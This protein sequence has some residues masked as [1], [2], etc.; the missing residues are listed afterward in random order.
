[1]SKGVITVNWNVR[2]VILSFQCFPQVLIAVF[3]DQAPGKKRS[4][5]KEGDLVIRAGTA[6]DDDET[7]DDPEF[8]F[9][10]ADAV[11]D[12]ELAELFADDGDDTAEDTT[13]DS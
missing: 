7:D 6:D 9:D 8:Q 5:I 4:E 12:E 2:A 13:T 11:T 3:Y 1:M 10:P